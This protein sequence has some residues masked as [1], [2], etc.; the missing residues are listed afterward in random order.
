MKVEVEFHPLPPPDP[1]FAEFLGYLEG[2]IAAAVGI[3]ASALRSERDEDE[4]QAF[5]A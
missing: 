5:A 4:E 1:G 2:C 3:P